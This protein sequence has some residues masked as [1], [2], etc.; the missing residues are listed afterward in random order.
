MKKINELM[1]KAYVKSLA[2]KEKIKEYMESEK[3]ISDL[4]ITILVLAI[5]VILI[6]VFWD[7][8]SEWLGDIMDNRSGSM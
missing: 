5:A 1:L 7:R 2:T 8:L 4:V 6:G 3:G